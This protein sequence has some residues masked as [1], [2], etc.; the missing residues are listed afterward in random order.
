MNADSGRDAESGAN[1]HFASA[2]RERDDSLS[3]GAP[4]PCEALRARMQARLLKLALTPILLIAVV[5]V[6]AALAW[7]WLRP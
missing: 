1:G 4:S 7:I 5:L 3:A 2:P 6:I